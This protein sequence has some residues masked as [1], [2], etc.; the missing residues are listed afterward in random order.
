M[1]IIA[2]VR[3]A[4]AQQ[5]VPRLGKQPPEE[6]LQLPEIKVIASA[7]L[8]GLPLSLSEVPATVQVI[9]GEE[10][11][12]SGAVTLQEPLTRLPGVTLNNEQGNA[13]QPGISLRGF[14]GTSV[15]GVPQGISVFL[16]GVRLNEP[17]VEEINF[18]L[19]PMDDI[20]RIE[21]IRGPCAV[22]GRNTLG[23]SLNIMT[24]RGA[25]RR[26]IVPEVAG[27][28]FGSQQ[29]R[30]RLG[31]TEGYIDY[32]F[33]GLYARQDGWRDESATRLGKGFGKVGVRYGGTDATL[34][35]LY[36]DNR[37]EQPGS[38][39]LSL[40]RQ[41]RTLN[42]TG[43]DFFSPRASLWT[44]NLR[45]E[46]GAGFALSLN[47]FG[48]ILDAEQ[49]NVSLI[50]DNTRSFTHTTSAG[51]TLQLSHRGPVLGRQNHLIVG[52]EYVHHDVS[53]QV[54]EEK[55]DRTLA[56]CFEAALA[57]GDDPAE[58]C[59]LQALSTQVSDKQNGAGFYVQDTLNLAR[60]LLLKTDRFVLTV[61][62]RWDWLR[63]TI[64]DESPP[65]AARPSATGSSTFSRFT[66]RVGVNYNLSSEYGIYVS[67]SQ[68]FRAPAFLELTCAGPGAICPGLQAGVAPDPPLQSVKAAHYEIGFQARPVLWLEADLALFRTDVR[69]D[70]FA[71]S[72]TGTVGLCFQNIGDTRRQG[73]ELSLR[74]TYQ[75]LL[76]A[77]VNYT[78]TQATFEV[79]T[80]L[81]TPRL[82]AGCVTTPCTQ[83]VRKGDEIPLIPTH[84]L[85]VSIDYHPMSWLTLSLTGSYVGQQWLRGD[86]ANQERPLSD[87]FV[88]N[89]RV[90]ARWQQLAG[91][92]QVNNLLN[93]T[94]ETFG[95]F[96]PNARRPGDPV[97]RFLTPAPPIHVL[98]GISYQF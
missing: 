15:T 1:V 67:Y 42:F 8:S 90:R 28:S 77:S 83:L 87:Y 10:L 5:Q 18:D 48:R 63:H 35:F 24:L 62:G 26:E 95:T 39:P 6:V 82:T 37:I 19:I 73:L 38:L 78:Y 69:D 14:Q 53:T 84:R 17:A 98:A 56:A 60:G 54:F 79:D 46:L 4:D 68:G 61:A 49:F 91:F 13:V 32:Y 93:N 72:P 33:S 92:V 7:R 11:R 55:N 51:G 29:Y 59:P 57:A 20:E 36:G 89:G 97:E 27:G 81:A 71:V 3:V 65:E 88:M 50:D 66:P 94:Y 85:N 9:T 31:G 40:L 75:R 30:L 2:C 43:G 34:S 70:I 64:L 23:G 12:Q 41:D 86:E 25:E 80:A 44:L 74:G 47:G 45:Q 52:A 22:F 96:A 58:A 16:N 76:D 21:L